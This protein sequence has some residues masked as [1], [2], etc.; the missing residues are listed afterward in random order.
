L[1]AFAAGG[2][3]Q[4]AGVSAGPQ[5]INIIDYADAISKHLV[6]DARE[7]GSY[8][9]GSIITW[10]KGE[11]SLIA[12]DLRTSWWYLLPPRPNPE[13]ILHIISIPPYLPDRDV[14]VWQRILLEPS[15]DKW[16]TSRIYNE[17]AEDFR[18]RIIENEAASIVTNLFMN[19]WLNARAG[20]YGVARVQ[21]VLPLLDVQHWCTLKPLSK[22]NDQLITD[23]LKTNQIIPTPVFPH[24]NWFFHSI[25]FSI[26][27]VEPIF[28]H[29]RSESL[30]TLNSGF[31]ALSVFYSLAIL[32]ETG[33]IHSDLS[34]GN[35]AVLPHVPCTIQTRRDST[36][37][38]RLAFTPIV[39][40]W[41]R[42]VFTNFND[43][44][45]TP[46]TRRACILYVLASS[47]ALQDYHARNM[48]LAVEWV[49]KLNG[50]ENT[51]QGR[52]D[53]PTVVWV[54]PKKDRK[55]YSAVLEI[56]NRILSLADVSIEDVMRMCISHPH[57]TGAGY[58]L[59]NFMK[60]TQR[61]QIRSTAHPRMSETH[62][63]VDSN[64][65]NIDNF[66]E[67]CGAHV[68]ECFDFRGSYVKAHIN[69]VTL[70]SNED[71][72]EFRVNG[73]HVF[74]CNRKLPREYWTHVGYGLGLINVVLLERFV[75]MRRGR[76]QG[77]GGRKKMRREARLLVF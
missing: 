46:A 27:A 9:G 24:T 31:W 57:L 65:V 37:D 6:K 15:T 36:G 8:A 29:F 33:V 39:T 11:S 73:N 58:S 13:S 75:E 21:P 38:V 4:T 23:P 1:V 76:A 61:V 50:W 7:R 14:P 77:G 55:I 5:F 40:D 2:A 22:P 70:S 53:V 43:D 18:R 20:R 63:F 25:L 72:T 47:L 64:V 74:W 52:L 41:D 17:S 35:M 56:Y 32:R 45:V 48:F 54:S 42:A 28:H 69:Y 51:A 49:R 59:N 3:K 67:G 12:N 68:N 16:K 10:R 66:M 19:H 71:G 30:F 44:D 62:T 34:T 26:P 60:Q